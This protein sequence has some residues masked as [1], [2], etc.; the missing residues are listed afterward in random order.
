MTMQ[1]RPNNPIDQR[2]AA[3]RK[4]SRDAL[5]WAG[6]GLAGGIAF[7]LLMQS[8]TILVLGLVI[9][10]AGGFVNWKKVQKIVNHQDR[11]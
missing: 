9:G 2:K 1:P 8:W 5:V 3:V 11:Y 6:G 7:G 4:Y 10:V